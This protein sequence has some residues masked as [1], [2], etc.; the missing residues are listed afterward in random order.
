MFRLLPL[1][2]QCSFIRL[3]TVRTRNT[4][5]AT[6]ISLRATPLLCRGSQSPIEDQDFN[7]NRKM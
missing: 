1:I 5:V 7:E 4:L 3:L 6:P 2:I